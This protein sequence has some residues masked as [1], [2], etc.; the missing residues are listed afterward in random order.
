MAMLVI[1]LD[2]FKRE[3]EASI[4]VAYLTLLSL[5]YT[6]LAGTVLALNRNSSFVHFFTVLC[7]A[8]TVLPLIL[9]SILLL[10]WIKKQKIYKTC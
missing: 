3:R 8:V 5:W 9:I 7:Y 10:Q 2:P 4:N 1:I 6:R